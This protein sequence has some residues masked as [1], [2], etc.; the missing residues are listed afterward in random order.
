M[1]V[2]SEYVKFIKV[3]NLKDGGS[4]YQF[5]C[6][7]KGCLLYM[8]IL[9]GEV[10]VIDVVRIV[11]VYE[12]FVKEYGVMIKNVMDIYL[13]VDYIFGGCKLVEKVGGM[14]WLL[15]KDVEEV[16]FLY[17][18]FV[19]GFVIM[20]G[21]IKIEIDV[22]YLLGYMIG[23]MLFIVDDFYLLLGDILFVDLIGCF[24]FVGKVEDW[25]SDLCNILY[26]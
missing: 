6:F 3:G 8:V 23:S 4:M 16:V 18:L 1:K 20:V 22:L 19:E 13:Y 9:N 15:L 5:N 12:E 2:W 26:S 21:G 17:E 24:D 11:E 10:V 14:Y 25:V 7:G